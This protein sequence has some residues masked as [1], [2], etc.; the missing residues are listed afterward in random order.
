MVMAKLSLTGNCFLLKWKGNISSSEGHR[1][2]R[3]KKIRI[4]AF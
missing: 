1:G 3:G 2:I 4:P